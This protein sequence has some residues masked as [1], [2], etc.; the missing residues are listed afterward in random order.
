MGDDRIVVVEITVEVGRCNGCWSLI[1]TAVI[2]FF[3][4]FT[5]IRCLVLFIVIII[6]FVTGITVGI[7]VN[8]PP[9]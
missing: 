1:F 7:T 4:W 5:M 9:I 3:S 2:I 8:I 6:A